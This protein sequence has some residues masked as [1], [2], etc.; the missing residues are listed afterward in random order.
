MGGELDA[1]HLRRRPRKAASRAHE[2]RRAPAKAAHQQ[3][4][5]DAAKADLK[6][7]GIETLKR[8]ASSDR[9]GS[10][11]GKTIADFPDLVAEWHPTANGD[12]RPE[13]V[14]AGSARMVWWK[15][16]D[17]PYHE[18]PTT[19]RSR[20]ISGSNCGFCGGK[21]VHPADSIVVTHPEVAAQWHPTKNGMKTSE[22]V[23]HGSS[24]TAW[25]QCSKVKGHIWRAQVSARTVGDGCRQCSAR[26][27][28]PKTVESR[29]VAAASA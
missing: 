7:R 15:C 16:P 10:V 5:R 28:K 27:R 2:A 25:W 12:L 4:R 14:P 26:G 29:S 24:F 1:C 18:W 20:T 23:T 13:D 21:R 8:R 11:A 17:R 19:A 22:Q 3:E 9:G 6:R